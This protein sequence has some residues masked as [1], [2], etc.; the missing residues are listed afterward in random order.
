VLHGEYPIKGLEY[1]EHRPVFKIFDKMPTDDRERASVRR[2][3]EW[4]SNLLSYVFGPMVRSPVR[5]AELAFF[6]YGIDEGGIEKKP[7]WD[8]PEW[9][10]TKFQGSNIAWNHLPIT[11]EVHLLYRTRVSTVKVAE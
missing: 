11:H 8:V 7:G 10:K 3:G 2:Y 5:A 4:V 9:R 6:Q 1:H